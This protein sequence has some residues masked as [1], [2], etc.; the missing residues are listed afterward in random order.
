MIL[1]L[2][3]NHSNNMLKEEVFSLKDTFI[4]LLYINNYQERSCSSREI[5]KRN[6]ERKKSLLSFIAFWIN[7]YFPASEYTAIALY[8]HNNT[9]LIKRCIYIFL[10][11]SRKLSIGLNI[12][13]NLKPDTMF[14]IEPKFSTKTTNIF[15]GRNN[16]HKVQYYN[17]HNKIMT[18]IPFLFLM[19]YPVEEMGLINS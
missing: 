9:N 5:L 14:R 4:I 17:Y 12:I 18:Q 2:G 16:L 8:C 13:P 19:S 1:V 3:N 15:L 6:K 11:P 7:S 10:L